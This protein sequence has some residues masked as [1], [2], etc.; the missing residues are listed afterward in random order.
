MDFGP[1]SNKSER[2]YEGINIGLQC[3]DVKF[4]NECW[5]QLINAEYCFN[6]HSSSNLFGCNGL[7][8]TEYCILNKQYTK[9]EYEQL[10]SK[11]KAK[12]T[13]DKEYG[14][15]FPMSLSPHA[16]NETVAQQ[17]FPLTKEQALAKG[18]RWRDMEEK[19]YTIG[20]DVL[21]CEH[22]GKCA[23]SC[24]M[25]FKM[26]PDELA[27]YE[28]FKIPHPNLCPNCRHFERLTKRNPL[29]LWDRNCEKCGAEIST[30]YAPDR[31]EMVYCI[32][33]YQ[34]LF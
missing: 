31:P 19:Q 18:Y 16:Y 26:I 1:W 24:T 7:R 27:F 21:A 15:Y 23:Q 12:M 10:V 13:N 2:M 20:G 33:C 9:E 6:C 32:Q 29:K 11:I 17:F 14:E 4:S 30:S 25:A 28:Q 34:H 3:A 8:K 22:A 5:S